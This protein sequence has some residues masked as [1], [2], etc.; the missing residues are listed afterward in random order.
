MKIFLIVAFFI[1][2]GI[3]KAYN[4]AKRMDDSNPIPDER[5]FGD[6]SSEDNNKE[7]FPQ[8]SPASGSELFPRENKQTVRSM[9]AMKRETT[10]MNFA[11]S[12]IGTGTHT[13]PQSQT[14]F[15]DLESEQEFNI[16]SP[17]DARRAIIW[18][19]ILQRKY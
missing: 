1:V 4:K 18:S 11:K 19:E 6:E 14:S 16:S 3:V 7:F 5:D 13:I 8:S 17:E 10:R 15:D 12:S 9:A 2:F